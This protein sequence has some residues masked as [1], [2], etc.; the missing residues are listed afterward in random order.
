MKVLITG[1]CGFIGSHVCEFYVQR[2]DQAIAYDN[3]TKYELTRTGYSAELARDY[4]RNVL[5]RMGVDIR[6]EDIRD[7]EKLALSAKECDFIVH[8]AAQPAM[9]IS[10]EDPELDFSTN[11]RGTFNVLEAARKFKIPVV[12]CGTIHIYGNRINDTLLEDTTRYRRDPA[13]I[14]E[15]EPVAQGCL[16]P[17]HASKRAG[18]LYVQTYID[19]YDVKAASFRL[20]GL[21]GSRQFGGEDHGWVANFAIRAVM[22][23]PLTIYGTG[24]QVRDIL[25]ATD[26]CEAFHAFYEKGAPGIYNIGGES[27]QAISLLE[28]IDII[29]EILGKRPEVNFEAG[30]HGDLRYFICDSTRARRRLGWEAKIGPREG[31]RKLMDWIKENDEIFT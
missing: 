19:T 26:L 7:A 5:E 23:R 25:Y 15:K 9:T 11:V 8:T 28:C 18:E 31:I 30:R 2:G 20:T 14:D 21:Y 10:W 16:T 24:K 1:G 4:N 3:M 17:L 29:E 13:E 12:S 6:V 27:R 22:G